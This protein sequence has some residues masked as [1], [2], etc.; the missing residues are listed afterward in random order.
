MTSY[1][2]HTWHYYSKNFQTKPYRR[3]ST[4]KKT[5]ALFA[6]NVSA[7]FTSHERRSTGHFPESVLLAKCIYCVCV[8]KKRRKKWVFYNGTA[9][10][11]IIFKP[12]PGPGAIHPC[13]CWCPWVILFSPSDVHA[14]LGHV[15]G[16]ETIWRQTINKAVLHLLL[17]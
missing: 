9:Y 8:C 13:P 15:T 2:V 4:H 7:T 10:D 17:L 16:F 14:L 5:I 3:I 1:I 12:K 11:V 6:W